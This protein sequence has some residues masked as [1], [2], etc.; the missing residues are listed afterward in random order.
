MIFFVSSIIM[1]I[2]NENFFFRDISFLLILVSFRICYLVFLRMKIVIIEYGV[3]INHFFLVYF[4]LLLL[5]LRF[6]SSRFLLFYIFFELSIFPIFVY[7]IKFGSSFKKVMAGYYVLFFTFF[8][9]LIFLLGL[10]G[11]FR[12]VGRMFF[13]HLII[14]KEYM[15]TF[16]YYLM[17]IVF[18]V[19][20]PVFFFHVWLPLA[21]VESPMIGSMILARLMLK[22]GTYGIFWL[23]EIFIGNFKFTYYLRLLG[24]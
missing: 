17:T 13:F 9:S 18:F 5:I 15:L 16:L 3:Y 14:F 24:L 6:Y 22:L 8:S 20:I 2:L 4:L 1:V 21:H 12:V 23:R 10:L 7:V 11:V 19:K